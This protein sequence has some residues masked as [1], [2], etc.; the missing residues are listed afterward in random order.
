MNGVLT[1]A[2]PATRPAPGPAPASF[3]GGRLGL[4]LATVIALALLIAIHDAITARE[5]LAKAR[6]AEAAEVAA[7][8]HELIALR[9]V[10]AQMRKAATPAEPMAPVIE[11][12]AAAEGVMIASTQGAGD[13]DAGPYRERRSIVRIAGAPL[14]PLK[15][16]LARIESAQPGLLIRELTVRRSVNRSDRLD[17]EIVLAQLDPSSAARAPEQRTRARDSRPEGER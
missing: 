7:S 15:R 12:V 17:A 10:V 11:R 8:G 9:D 1:S 3:P 13:A 2:A 16:F 4:A 14:G 5:R 6:E